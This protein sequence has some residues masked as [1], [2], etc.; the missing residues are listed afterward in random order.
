MNEE[1]EITLVFLVTIG[2]ELYFNF[3]MS[4]SSYKY[5]AQALGREVENSPQFMMF[6]ALSF[7]ISLH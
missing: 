3:F 1:E 7:A 6:S 5:L 2:L 4:V